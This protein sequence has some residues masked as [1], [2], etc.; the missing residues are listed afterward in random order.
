MASSHNSG[1]AAEP[2]ALWLY[3]LPG[4]GVVV[5]Q[6]AGSPSLEELE[7]R[8]AEPDGVNARIWICYGSLTQGLTELVNRFQQP[9]QPLELETEL[10]RWQADFNRAAVVKRRWRDQVRLVNLG[11][12]GTGLLAKELPPELSGGRHLSGAAH[13]TGTQSDPQGYWELAMRVLLEGRPGLL[14]AWLDAEHWADAIGVEQAAGQGARQESPDWRQPMQLER[15]KQVLWHSDGTGGAGRLELEQRCVQL[16][17]ELALERDHGAMLKRYI[18]HM[19]K[20]LDHFLANHERTA[21]L[22]ERLPTL[23]QRAR[24][25]LGTCSAQ[26]P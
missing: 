2:K 8:Q 13:S 20:E 26:L 16:E 1:S 21:A 15:L 17:R 5:P 25:Q 7:Q 23:L 12:G 22:A 24:Q 9:P 10:E 3:G 19:E 14:H 6:A 18:Q 11:K 4:S